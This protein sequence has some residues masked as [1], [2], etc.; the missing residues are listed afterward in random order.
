MSKI[1][2]IQPHKMLQQAIALSLFPDHEL[3]MAESIPDSS[4][5]KDFDALIID[6][7]SLKETNG[8]SAPGIRAVQGWKVPTIWIEGAESSQTPSRDNLVRIKRPIAREALLSALAECL[9]RSFGPKRSA[10]ATE[11]RQGER[12]SSKAAAKEK[13]SSASATAQQARFIE[14]VEVVEEGPGVKKGKAQERKKK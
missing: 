6:A 11:A 13:K 1:L 14:L 8:L 12:S 7:A 2:V 10:P 9:G 4:A 5:V 3:Q